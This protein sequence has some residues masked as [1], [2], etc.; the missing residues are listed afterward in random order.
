MA[1]TRSGAP[2]GGKPAPVFLHIG[3]MKTG[4]TYL[5]R[6]LKQN[7]P[8]LESEGFLFPGDTWKFQVRAAEDVLNAIPEDAVIERQARG[9]WSELAGQVLN[10]GGA[11]SVVSME[12]LSHAW[13]DRARAALAALEP[14]EV[15]VVLGV[16]DAARIIPAQ[17][18]TSVRSSKTH[19]WDEFRTSV[20][21]ARGLRAKMTRFSDPTA[22][23]FRRNQDI[24][25]MLKV[26]GPLVPTGHLHVV[27]VPPSGGDPTQLWRRF[28]AVTGLDP[29]LGGSVD[30]V[31]ES[32]GYA[33]TELIRRVNLR[34]GE[35]PPV[36]YNDTIRHKLSTNILTPH[37]GEESPALLD[38]A[39]L[40]FA[41]RWNARTR[42]AIAA[43]GVP[44]EGD[45]DDLPTSATERHLAQVDDDQQPPSTEE[46]VAAA[47]VAVV[48]LK[49][50][51]EQRARRVR[52][53]GVDI[54]A[55]AREADGI[56]PG[57]SSASDPAAQ[58][59]IDVARLCEIAMEIRRQ[60]RQS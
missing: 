21:R 47:E 58:A 42:D 45:L 8:A 12:F 18:Q 20:R 9:A 2:G 40:D 39:T 57:W 16:R 26:W 28:A 19:G 5:Q 52:R 54:S 50:L 41:L 49:E 30:R 44:V 33:S 59:T 6:V 46:L 14:A 4:T 53:K 55:L 60:R 13:P 25:R 7:K 32:L 51:V 56:A 43:A 38:S 48:G 11:A 3:A 27:T 23:R 35:V 15:H 29:E 31:N 1:P 10:H 17:W 22:V 36:D 37:S 34:L 24:D